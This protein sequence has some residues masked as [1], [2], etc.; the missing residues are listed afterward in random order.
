LYWLLEDAYADRKGKPIRQSDTVRWAGKRFFQGKKFWRI[1]TGY[2]IR[3]D[4]VRRF[5]PSR[6][7]G[8]DLLKSGKKLPL[9]FMVGKRRR[10]IGEKIPPIPVHRGPEGMIISHLDRYTAWPVDRVVWRGKARW[11]RIPKKGWVASDLSRLAR[12][13]DRPKAAM[14]PD[15]RWIDVDLDEN[16]LVAYQGS[17]PVYAT[18]VGSGVWKYPTP[19]GVFRIYKKSAEADMKS[20]QT[21]DEKY[22]VDHVPWSMYFKRGYALHGT[23]WHNGFGHSRSHGCVNLSARDARFLYH[24]ARPVVPDGWTLF[25]ADDKHPGTVV[26]M[27]GK[28]IKKPVPEP[29]KKGE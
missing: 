26:R 29:R 23:Y 3:G 24:W 7:K 25:L 5:W 16:T 20:E 28:P 18:L 11:F 12:T 9:V 19:R 1:T 4:R 15:E 14:H 8:V 17:T 13:S 10:K 22:R 21:A 6:F 27:R 2:F